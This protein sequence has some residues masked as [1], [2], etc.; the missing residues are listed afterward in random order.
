MAWS[1]DMCYVLLVQ[2]VC[3][4]FYFDVCEAWV[5]RFS[6]Q[7]LTCMH[8]VY[9]ALW[10]RMVLCESFLMRHMYKLSFIH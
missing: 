4:S 3:K 10:T 5:W 7:E 9:L 1:G 6:L 8:C 2:Y